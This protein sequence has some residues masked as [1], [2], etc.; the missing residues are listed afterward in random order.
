MRENKFAK[1]VEQQH[2][3]NTE[4]LQKE[5]AMY[6]AG[7]AEE[8]RTAAMGTP[9]TEPE[10]K[11]VYRYHKNEKETKSVRRLILLKPSNDEWLKA[12]ARKNSLSV[13][14]LINQMVESQK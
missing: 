4:Y 13:N 8:E 12:T 6:S 2:T 14:E 5:T 11:I 7:R 3:E 9:A 1:L 10:P